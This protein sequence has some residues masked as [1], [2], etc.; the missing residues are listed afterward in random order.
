MLTVYTKPNCGQCSF[1]K[2]RLYRHGIPFEEKPITQEVLDLAIKY[3][4][5]S[6]PIV[7]PGDDWDR[8]WSGLRVNDIDAY[9]EENS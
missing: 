9:I 1:T 4:F 6:A 7:V 2:D 3:G 5:Q 8:A